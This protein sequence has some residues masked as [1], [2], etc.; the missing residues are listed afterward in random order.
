MTDWT[1]ADEKNLAASIGA[2]ASQNTIT[3]E[4][5]ASGGADFVR[6]QLIAQYAVKRQ[7]AAI[8]AEN[9]QLRE[10]ATALA[11]GAEAVLAENAELRAR[12]AKLESK[13]GKK[14]DSA[15]DQEAGGA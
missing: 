9:A 10:D 7:I 1:L 4:Q 2:R 11:E 8:M 15:S 5:Y 3:P 6:S 13:R 14:V 12:L